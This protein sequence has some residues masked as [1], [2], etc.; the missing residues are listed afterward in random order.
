VLVVPRSLNIVHMYDVFE[1]DKNVYLVMDLCTGGE[2][3]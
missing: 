1:D 3:W 2:L